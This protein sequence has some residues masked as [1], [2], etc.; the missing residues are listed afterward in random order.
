MYADE[1]DLSAAQYEIMRGL[2]RS[3]K[4]VYNPG[5][6]GAL[7]RKGFVSTLGGKIVATDIGWQ[8]FFETTDTFK[9]VMS[10]IRDNPECDLKYGG[11]LVPRAMKTVRTLRDLGYFQGNKVFRKT[12]KFEH[13]IS[14]IHFQRRKFL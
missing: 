3:D 4:L 9:A 12:E 1:I 8:S 14:S 11:I 7:I 5:A 10:Y 2:I 13:T 6:W